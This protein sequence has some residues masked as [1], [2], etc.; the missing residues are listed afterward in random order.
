MKSLLSFFAYEVKGNQES[1]TILFYQF[2]NIPVLL[3]EDRVV[4]SYAFDKS[5]KTLPTNP[6]L[7]NSFCQEGSNLNKACWVLCAI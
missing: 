2:C 5:I 3:L 4:Q 1:T 6:F 7:S